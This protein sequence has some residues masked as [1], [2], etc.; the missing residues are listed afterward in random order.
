[1]EGVVLLNER[2]LFIKTSPLMSES[3]SK[4]LLFRSDRISRLKKNVN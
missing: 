2:V 1:M 3:V 4:L